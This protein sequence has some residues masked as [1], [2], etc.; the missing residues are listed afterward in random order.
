[1]WMQLDALMVQ[2]K[3]TLNIS[4]GHLDLGPYFNLNHHCSQ[5]STPNVAAALPPKLSSTTFL[6]Q[7]S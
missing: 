1:M 3:S 7:Q 5:N 2:V 4:G 6:L